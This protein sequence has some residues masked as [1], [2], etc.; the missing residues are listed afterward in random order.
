VA[1]PIG[2][3]SLSAVWRRTRQPAQPTA[4]DGA[5]RVGQS[6]DNDDLQV[7][8]WA[9]IQAAE[10]HWQSIVKTMNGPQARLREFA[11][12]A[13]G[14]AVALHQRASAGLKRGRPTREIAAN[15]QPPLELRQDAPRPG[16]VAAWQ[17]LDRAFKALVAAK[18]DPTVAFPTLAQ[19]WDAL[20]KAAAGLADAIDHASIQERAV[21]SFCA[22]PACEVRRLITGPPG[23]G[24]CNE[25]VQLCVE[26]L[27]E[28]A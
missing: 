27:E 17:A 11:A 2:V 8:A 5:D 16:P 22:K 12:A 25:C 24:I 18:A 21:C 20:A 28:E 26:V 7:R 3:A 13:Q 9:A 19:A 6:E 15:W 1:A 14:M 4:A 10:A 23:L